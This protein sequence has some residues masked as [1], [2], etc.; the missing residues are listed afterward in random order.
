[1]PEPAITVAIASLRGGPCLA[2]CLQA[3]VHQTERDFEVIV[4]DNSGTGAIQSEL[5]ACTFAFP[6]RV[7]RSSYNLGFGAAV[8]QAWAMSAAGYLAT[9]NDDAEPHP[10]WL[11]ALR[12]EMERAP[13]LGMCAS[14]VRLRGAGLLDSAGMLICMDGS[15]KQRGHRELPALYGQPTPVLLPS[16]SAALYRREMLDDAG[17]FDADFFLYCEDTDLGLR[18]RR[19]GWEC[20]YVPDAIVDHRYSQSS[21]AASPLKVWYIERNRLWV[22]AKNFPLPLLLAA[23]WHS[24]LRYFWHLVYL[25]QNRGAAAQ[26]R[27]E[28]NGALALIGI[29]I[30]A[31]GSVLL[32][33]KQLMGKRRAIREHARVP[34]RQFTALLKRFSLSAREIARL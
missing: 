34:D 4:V 17:L 15:S 8:N 16:A 32:H 18:A 21:S 13:G 3:L 14:Q 24:A 12:R 2:A 28:G 30:R 5:Q 7:Y 33:G 25:L 23:P 9:L 1:M 6:L 22:A 31:H 27:S 11:A 10:G 19:N 20:A 26:F 29:V